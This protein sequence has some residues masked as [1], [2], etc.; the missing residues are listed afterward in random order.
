MAVDLFHD[1]QSFGRS[2]PSVASL[3]VASPN[4]VVSPTFVK[5]VFEL[6]IVQV[7]KCKFLSFYFAF[8]KGARPTWQLVGNKGYISNLW[9]FKKSHWFLSAQSLQYFLVTETVCV[10]NYSHIPN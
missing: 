5:K 10:F 2:W 6:K 8:I 4:L 9:I 1:K 3:A 7:A